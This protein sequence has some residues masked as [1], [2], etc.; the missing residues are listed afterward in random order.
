[1]E[2]FLQADLTCPTADQS[3]VLFRAQIA[4]PCDGSALSFLKDLVKSDSY[5]M[6]VLGE[7]LAVFPD[8]PVEIESLLASTTCGAITQ[9]EMA[10]TE[11]PQNTTALRGAVSGV[12]SAIVVAVLLLFVAIY[13]C[14]RRLKKQR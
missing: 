4:T 11:A 6:I 10:L 12:L 3:L 13:C 7:I 2:N 8:C 1:M 14:S 9:E 5:Y